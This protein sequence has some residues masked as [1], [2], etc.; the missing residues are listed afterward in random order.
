MTALAAAA[1]FLGASLQ[2]ATGFGFALIAAP[3]MFA[4]F[5]PHEAVTA[6][7]LLGAEISLLTLV[8]EGRVPRVLRG[9][10]VVLVAWSLPG[11]ALGALALR[12]LPERLLSAFVAIGV[13][14]GLALRLRARGARS[15]GAPVRSRRWSAPLA[16]VCS[17]ALSTSTALNG[18]PIVLHLL[19][20]GASSEQMRDTLAAVFVALAVLSAPALAITGTFAVPAAVAALLAAGLAGQLVG[21]RLFAR[22]AGERYESVV[23]IVLALAALI[24]LATSVV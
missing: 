15:A 21:R 5:G 3:I 10:A 8:T 19:A 2:S 13:L 17:G 6:G 16:G 14:G 7:V 22:L 11:L 20:R 1:V 12:E 9:E 18:P 23:L 24:A 4:A